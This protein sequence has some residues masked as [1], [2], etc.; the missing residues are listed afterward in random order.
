MTTHRPLIA[1]AG[2]ALDP[3]K[4][5]GWRGAA[6]GVQVAYIHALH[7]AGGEEAILLPIELDED[8]AARRLSRFDGLLLIGGGDVHP[9]LYGEESDPRL[10]GLNSTSDRFEIPVA[11]AAAHTG[12]PTLAVCRGIQVLNV[13]L[14]GTLLQHIELVDGTDHGDPGKRVATHP[15]DLAPGSRIAAVMSAPD[16]G[17]PGCTSEHHQAVSRLGEGLT[18][19]GWAPDGVVEAVEYDEGWVLGIQWHP[20]VTA[21]TDPR[22]QALFD[23]LVRRAAGD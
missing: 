9:S 4:V 3:G 7:R 22:Q 10:W 20:E 19:T 16:L 14:G 15:V 18:P 11:R 1:V 17:P 2:R 23:A 8:E 12:I 6:V 13:A 21:A 5:S